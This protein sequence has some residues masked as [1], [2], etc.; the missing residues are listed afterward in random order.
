MVVYKPLHALHGALW[1]LGFVRKWEERNRMAAKNAFN[2]MRRL[3]D[4]LFINTKWSHLTRKK[5]QW[6]QTATMTT[7][8]IIP[9]SIII[10]Y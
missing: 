10:N 3:Q 2:H 8:V 6:L 4:L 7:T 1:I 5:L 9:V